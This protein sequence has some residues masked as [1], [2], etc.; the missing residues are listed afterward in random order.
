MK[1]ELNERDL[2]KNITMTVKVSPDWRVG[3][4]LL[5]MRL[6]AWVSGCVFEIEDSIE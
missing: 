5:I 3:L 1:A 4:G 2:M 6:G